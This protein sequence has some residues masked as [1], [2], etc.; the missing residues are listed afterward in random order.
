MHGL[1]WLW[2]V[3]WRNPDGFLRGVVPLWLGKHSN[4]M[5]W[6]LVPQPSDDHML[7]FLAMA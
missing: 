4:T 3:A 1:V 2:L 6:L 7:N 5:L